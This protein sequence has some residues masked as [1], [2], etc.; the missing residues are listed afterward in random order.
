MRENDEV[1]IKTTI[2]SKK[3]NNKLTYI[4]EL[5][6]PRSLATDPDNK[7][8]SFTFLS[9]NTEKLNID[10]KGP[11]GYQFVID[12]IQ[13][14]S[15]QSLSFS[16]TARYKQTTPTAKIDVADQDLIT[17]N[18]HKDTYPDITINSMDA[19]VKNRWILFNTTAGNK[20]SYEQVYDDIQKDMN[21]Y[22]S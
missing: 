22:N 9:G 11:E 17:Q 21:E 14:D 10:R 13:L 19:C 3:N 15:G 16:Y 1:A 4:D 18:K 5:K 20:T 12:N 8:S 7:I 2:I 6:G